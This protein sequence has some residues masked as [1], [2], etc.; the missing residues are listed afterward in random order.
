[1]KW[2]K[3]LGMS[4]FAPALMWVMKEVF[5][6]EDECLLCEPDEKEGRFLLNEIMNTGNMGHGETRFQWGQKS[7]W[8]RFVAAQRRNLHLATHYPHEVLWSPIFNVWRFFWLKTKG[9]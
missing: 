5:G 1:M 4:R 7:A 8:G 6:L 3:R 9:L 2:V